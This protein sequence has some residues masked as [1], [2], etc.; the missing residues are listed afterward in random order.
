MKNAVLIQQIYPQHGYSEI[1]ELTRKHN[2]NYCERHGFDYW[3]ILD[4]VIK[5]RDAHDGAWAKI[6]LIKQAL[7]KGYE[8]IVWLDADAMI[9]DVSVDLRDAVE[10]YKIGA[11]WHRIPQLSHW[12]VG[13]LYVHNCE[14]VKAFIETWAA[15]Y[16]APNDG[17]LEQGVFNRL[18]M[19]SNI[20]STVSDKW[21]STFDVSLV[22][23]AVVLGFHGQGDIKQRYAMMKETFNRLFPEQESV[24]QGKSEVT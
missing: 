9:K 14:E 18:A 11:C 16:P 12:N 7:D 13:V 2:E 22:P 20:V 6:E 15:G 3:H 17:W 23:D 19:Q 8:Y 21:N 1:M 4:D 10:F 24:T 5:G